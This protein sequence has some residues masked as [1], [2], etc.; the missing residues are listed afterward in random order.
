MGAGL[1]VTYTSSE[2]VIRLNN[3][4]SPNDGKLEYDADAVGVTGSASL[5][6]QFNDRTRVGLVYTGETST[7]LEGDL[8][9]SRLGPVL[10]ATLGR[11]A[12]VCRGRTRGAQGH[13]EGRIDSSAVGTRGR[14]KIN[15]A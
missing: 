8:D 7:D 13:G 3:P 5:L 14:M 4:G 11:L 9:F 1:N 15:T 12:R 6:Y 10:G 2:S